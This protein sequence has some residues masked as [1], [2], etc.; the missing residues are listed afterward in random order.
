MNNEDL[1]NSFIWVTLKEEQDFLKIKETLTRIG[2][3]SYKEPKTLYQSCHILHKQ[4]KYAIVH[5]KEMFALDGKQT[6]FT[7]ED[8]FRRNMI[9][10]LLQ[11]WN[12]CTINNPSKIESSTQSLT[13]KVIPF[14]EKNSWVLE[15]KYSIGKQKN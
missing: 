7:D 11:E 9:A 12:L 6:N 10:N 1:L 5:F 8:R 3:A 15:S 4:G 2:I 14:K 13:V